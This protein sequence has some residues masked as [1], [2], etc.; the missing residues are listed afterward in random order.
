MTSMAVLIPKVRTRK[1][2]TEREYVSYA[3]AL[4][5]STPPSVTPLLT[6]SPRYILVFNLSDSR[7]MSVVRLSIALPRN[8]STIRHAFHFARYSPLVDLQ[9]VHLHVP[10]VHCAFCLCDMFQPRPVYCRL[11][12]SNTARIGKPPA[13]TLQPRVHRSSCYPPLL[14]VA[15][16]LYT[17]LPVSDAATTEP[18]SL[19][20]FPVLSSNPA[21]GG[22]CKVCSP[23]HN[24]KTLV[25]FDM[26]IRMF[27]GL[28]LHDRSRIPSLIHTKANPRMQ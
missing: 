8:I 11:W 14:P 28:L 3:R 26:S 16:S 19:P 2:V 10:S 17:A 23:P 21:I 7:N 13:I 6:I 25:R 5:Q 24:P 1:Q 22:P 9:P 12:C 27:P 4:S 15:K 20:P 18:P